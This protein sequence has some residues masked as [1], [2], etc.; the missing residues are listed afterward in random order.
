MLWLSQHLSV[1][2]SGVDNNDFESDFQLSLNEKMFGIGIEGGIWADWHIWGGCSLIGHAGG[3]IMCSNF[4]NK[5]QM[6]LITNDPDNAPEGLI[7]YKDHVLTGTP[8]L[9]Y[10]LGL[11]YCTCLWSSVVNV[12]IGWEEHVFFDVNQMSV[13]GGNLTLQGL[14][15]GAA[16]AF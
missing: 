10:F 5:A 12:R 14:T 11:Q 3:S 15:L 9:D 2:G 16:V 13:N 8:S 7:H 6:N 4:R 1:D